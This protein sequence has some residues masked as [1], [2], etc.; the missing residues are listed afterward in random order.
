MRLVNQTK[1]IILADEVFLAGRD[2]EG[3][4]KIREN[5]LA[6]RTA[7]L[8]KPANHQVTVVKVEASKQVGNPATESSLSSD[9]SSIKNGTNLIYWQVGAFKLQANA[10]KMAETLSA[11]LQYPVAVYAENGWY[12]VRFGGFATRGEANLCRKTILDHSILPANLI[13]EIHL[14]KFVKTPSL[15]EKEPSIS[16]PESNEKQDLPNNESVEPAATEPKAIAESPLNPQKG[17]VVIKKSTPTPN[18]S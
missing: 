5:E 16:Q 1:N 12:K 18:A 3:V 2:N 15:N 13:M 14:S 10:Q 17:L 8:V 6:F 4:R 9:Y 11:A 7:L